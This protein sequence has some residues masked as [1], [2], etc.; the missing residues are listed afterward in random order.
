MSE[1]KHPLEKGTKVKYLAPKCPCKG[2]GYNVKSG[3]VVNIVEQNNMY[4]YSVAGEG[5]A[6]PQLGII[7]II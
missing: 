7:E 3:S 5:R 2:K 1:I 4:V 6:I